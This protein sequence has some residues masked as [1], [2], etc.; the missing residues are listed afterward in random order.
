L[1]GPRHSLK[2]AALTA[3]ATI[4]LLGG[5]MA[6]ADK[7]ALPADPIRADDAIKTEAE[8]IAAA[9]AECERA[10]SVTANDKWKAQL[11]GGT[12]LVR[13]TEIK[14]ELVMPFSKRTG[15]PVGISCRPVLPEQVIN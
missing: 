14:G 15:K 13:D 12:W 6:P 11:S 8:A 10:H 5:C 1:S 7:P 2:R 9:K 3:G 4:L